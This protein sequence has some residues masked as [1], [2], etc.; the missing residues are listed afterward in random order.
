MPR[1]LVAAG[2]EHLICVNGSE[3]FDVPSIERYATDQCHPNGDGIEVLAE[4]FDSA[5]MAKLLD[6]STEMEIN[7]PPHRKSAA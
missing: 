6:Q 4:N 5:V 1:R 2:D 3:V 7:F